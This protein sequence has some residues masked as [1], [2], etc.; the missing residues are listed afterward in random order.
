MLGR[1]NVLA[2]GICS[3]RAADGR[4]PNRASLDEMQFRL[5]TVPSRGVFA[6]Y[7]MAFGADPVYLSMS[8]DVDCDSDFVENA[9]IPGHFAQQ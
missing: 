4:L 2:R 3:P 9:S 6:T 8:R 5:S 7:E 1:R